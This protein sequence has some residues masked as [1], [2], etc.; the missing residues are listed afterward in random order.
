MTDL[1]IKLNTAIA[2]LGDA[3]KSLEKHRNMSVVGKYTPEQ[4][5]EYWLPKEDSKESIMRRL[6]V[7]RGMLN[8]INRELKSK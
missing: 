1:I 8:E 6:V 7:V 4:L 2:V 5:K 3:K